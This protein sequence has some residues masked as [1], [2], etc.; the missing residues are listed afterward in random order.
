MDGTRDKTK[1]DAQK[2]R[3]NSFV[4]QRKASGVS[5]L[6]NHAMHSNSQIVVGFDPGLRLTG[7]GV[8]ELG[9]RPVLI[10][11]GVLRIA[12]G[13]PL[14]VRLRQLHEGASEVLAEH[15]PSAVAVEELFSH[16]D[17][18]KTAILMGHARGVIYLA[19]AQKDLPVTSYLPTR[20]KKT[21]TGSGRASKAQMQVAV[22][23]EF[24][25]A[26]PPSPSDVADALA[27]ALCHVYSLRQAG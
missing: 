18:P 12:A 17:R 21:M 1:D 10:E 8:V 20:V 9:V 7:Y 2:W 16:Y 23:S 13:R 26:Q 11:A 25:L 27:V 5:A 22:Q 15:Q 6:D 24:G 4:E 14:S 3:R 19:A